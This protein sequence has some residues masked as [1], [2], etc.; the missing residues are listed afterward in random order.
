M[1]STELVWATRD[2]D[3][4]VFSYRGGTTATT[5]YSAADTMTGV[6]EPARRLAAL[7]ED[8]ARRSP[9]VPVDLVAHSM[10]GLVSVAAVG[11]YADPG[12]AP[13]SLITLGTPH[14]GA[15]LA[16]AAALITASLG[17]QLVGEA[18]TAGGAPGP[19]S[20]SMRDLAPGSPLLETIGSEA[21][22]PPTTRIRSV[23]AR[24]DLI[25]PRGRTL[26]GYPGAL[27]VTVDVPDDV[28]THDSL[29]GSDAAH[30]E[31]ALAL[32]GAPPT[33]RSVA[34]QVADAATSVA[35]QKATAAIAAGATGSLTAVMP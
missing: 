21:R 28:H 24:T 17:G 30:R 29:P 12:V 19:R 25:V 32:A 6:E 10:G 15:D 23:G 33:C 34:D 2:A 20:A 27:S 5:P 1:M 18:L 7:L 14:G 35:I 9:G 4:H 13:A 26:A 11:L 8:L 3:V 31:I 16:R 22:F